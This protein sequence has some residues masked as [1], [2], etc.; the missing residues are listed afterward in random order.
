LHSPNKNANIWGCRLEC[1]LLLYTIGLLYYKLIV[2]YSCD[3]KAEFSAAIT[4]VFSVTWSFRKHFNMLIT[5]TV[6]L[7]IINLISI[8]AEKV[9]CIMW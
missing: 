7:L 3:G 2:I 9:Q 6:V 8:N 4:P 5:G 1:S